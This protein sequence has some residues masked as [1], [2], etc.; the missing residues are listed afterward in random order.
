MLRRALLV[1]VLVVLAL[2]GT[3]VFFTRPARLQAVFE[4]RLATFGYHI[5]RFDH[6]EFTPW[7]GLRIVNL[8]IAAVLPAEDPKR[9]SIPAL[10]IGEA[11]LRCALMPLLVGSVRTT[12]VELVRPTL[13]LLRDHD[14]DALPWNFSSDEGEPLRISA[15]GL[16]RVRVEDA[17]VQ[18]YSATRGVRRLLRRWV[19]DADGGASASAAGSDEYALRIAQVGG[20]ARG[21][22]SASDDKAF[23]NVRVR[24]GAIDLNADSIDLD[25]VLSL[26]PRQWARRARDLGLAGNA[27]LRELTFS[28]HG[29]QS[30]R[31]GISALRGSVPIERDAPTAERFVQFRGMDGELAL[32]ISSES[33]GKSLSVRAALRG[34]LNDGPCQ[35]SFRGAG[36]TIDSNNSHDSAAH[37]LSLGDLRMSDFDFSGHIERIDLPTSESHRAFIQSEQ[38]PPPVRDFFDHYK[39]RGPVALRWDYTPS[40]LSGELTSL[41][42]QCRYFRFPYVVRDVH[43]AVRLADGGVQL[44]AL[45]GRHGSSRI[46]ADGRLAHTGDWTAFDL[47][48]QG[49][50]VTLD[51][52]LYEALPEEY[53]AMWRQAAPLGLCDTTVR[54][55]RQEGTR[56]A[57]PRKPVVS[58]DAQ[59]LSGS[60]SVGADMRLEQS[61]AA[62]SINHGVL[63]LHDAHGY[64]GGGAVRF[65]GVAQASSDG[66]AAE[67]SFHVEASGLP[68]E[69]SSMIAGS[70]SGELGEIR[71]AGFGDVWGRI[72]GGA[73]DADRNFTIRINDGV[74]TGFDPRSQWRNARGWATEANGRQRIISFFAK[75][76]DGTLRVSGAVNKSGQSVAAQDFDLNAN[77][78]D[79]DVLL[80]SA[81]PHGFSEIREMLGLSGKG[82]LHATIAATRPH[83]PVDIHV[84]AERMH[85]PGFP[86]PLRDVSA[87][88]SVLSDRVEIHEAGARS[89][90]S[91][92]L[93]LAG[94]CGLR[95]ETFW[96]D[97][98]VDAR[99]IEL[100]DALINAL[101]S[102]LADM[103][104]Q[105]ALRGMANL[106]LARFRVSAKPDR[107][108]EFVGRL[109]LHD[110]SLRLGLPL[111]SFDGSLDGTCE[112]DRDGRIALEADLKIADGF[113]AKRA[114]HEWDARVR[115]NPDDGW[116]S[117]EEI[118]GEVAGGRATGRVRFDPETSR[119]EASLV[120]HDVDFDRFFLREAD[121]DRAFRGGRLDGRVFV[122]GR[123][124][125]PKARTGG[126][127]FRI[128]DGSLLSSK[129]TASV[130]RA[131][132]KQN[133]GIA[134]QVQRALVRFTWRGRTLSF[135][136]IDIQTRSTRFVGNGS[137]DTA[138]DQVDLTLVGAAP[139]D[140]LRLA[141]ITDLLEFAGAQL[142]QYH[143][144]GPINAPRVIAR[145]LHVLTDPIRKLLAGEPQR[146]RP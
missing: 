43:G 117:L 26:M 8:H 127:E 74:I 121:S 22:S 23:A 83:A 7:A 16:P 34:V 36:L 62:F 68:I 73:T 115:R 135:S 30:V 91:G 45:I 125:D 71:F 18:L 5:E 110:A 136:A 94:E 60:L 102:G 105:S 4:Q 48:F 75:R 138:G 124:D 49:R 146:E 12:D 126:G 67:Q 100:D 66:G 13:T 116:I 98:R 57:G 9:F 108:W 104:G 107:E 54:V 77:D 24:A 87:S 44:D 17:D 90:A 39:P 101:P 59:L 137:W 1:L 31:I 27:G 88:L 28:E 86:F 142:L 52:D 119:Y 82:A 93:T 80:R 78:P 63:M 122:R 131:S 96:C 21:R 81:L 133:P 58:V 37:T 89:G 120:L 53:K 76:G 2:A 3:Y 47:Q 51:R 129:V 15:A 33:G 143:V 72:R 123:V 118:R 64:V 92:S 113:L 84:D 140:A 11:R 10:R 70:D 14:A 85:S 112:L 32:L 38:L 20:I 132:R 130:L 95:P 69:R 19:F 99:D 55:T 40:G 56:E 109:D 134:D 42:A 106:K 29:L 46:R 128:R 25:L 141:V 50:N 144:E 111:E 97:L 79:I 6:I 61:D 139:Q 114:I 103:L 41:G 145:P 35:L 65:D